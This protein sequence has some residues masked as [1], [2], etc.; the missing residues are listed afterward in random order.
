[1]IKIKKIM[2]VLPSID[3]G[4]AQRFMLNI[5]ENIGKDKSNSY[6][7]VT[8]RKVKNNTYRDKFYA[9]NNCK[10]IELNKSKASFAFLDLI[11]LY[12]SI[13]PDVIFT[14]ISNSEKIVAISKIFYFNC[15][16]I[17]RKA[18]F[19]Y[20]K[21]LIQRIINKLCF[22]NLFADKIIVLT[23]DMEKFYLNNILTKRTK[24][25]RIPNM[26]DSGMISKMSLE[27]NGHPWFKDEKIK[28]MIGVG[29]LVEQKNFELIIQIF[30][31]LE[32]SDSNI[33]LII[34]GD[35]ELKNSLID[36]VGDQLL[37]KVDF[38]KFTDNPYSYMY[39]S[40][41][42]VLTSKFEGFPNII[43]EAFC[44]KVPVVSIN[45]PTGP[46]E[47]IVNMKNGI[48][49]DNYDAEEFAE[50]IKRVLYDKALSN[51]FRDNANNE[52]IKYQTSE[53]AELYKELFINI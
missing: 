46:R 18:S 36:K 30:K 1:M 24:I 28:V 33:R 31:I 48:L 52:L 42:F 8:M 20:S 45:C 35:G 4:G 49:I 7:L 43:L 34:V 37:N 5:L 26:I 9:L 13:K 3:V 15:K 39:N 44:C 53:V 6:F 16:L 22:E 11:R 47:L 10:I 2:F 41:V 50:K 40:D 21:N 29:R 25:K 32:K 23:K 14:T 38:V 27:S 12:Y 51:K 19:P 17:L